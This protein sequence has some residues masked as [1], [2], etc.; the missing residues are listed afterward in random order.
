MKPIV[1]IVGRPSVGKTSIFNLLTKGTTAKKLLPTRDRQYADFVVDDREYACIDTGGLQFKK[2]DRFAE[3]ILD[4]INYAIQEATIIMLVIDG[5]VGLTYD[6][7]KIV[8]LIRK[9]D[10]NIML[11]VN[12]ADHMENLGILNKLG[13]SHVCYLNSLSRKDITNVKEE[14]AGITENIIGENAVVIE[15]DPNVIKLAIVGRPNVGKSTLVNRLLG[16]NRTIISEIPG[17]TLASV[18]IPYEHK[19]KKFNLIDTAGI[20][21][22]KKI[23]DLLEKKIISESLRAIDFAD[24]VVC[25]VDASEGIVDQD[26]KLISHIVKVGKPVII[27]V[28]KI[29]LLD[30]LEQKKLHDQLIF[31]LK[32]A[33]FLQIYQISALKGVK[34][35]GLMSLVHKTFNRTTQKISTSTLNNI[36]LEAMD[37]H[38]PP[39]INKRRA[40]LKYAH[41]GSL[42]PHIIIIHGTR[43][44]DLPKSYTRYLS[45]C[46]HKSLNLFGVQFK[47]VFKEK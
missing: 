26:F 43:T 29:D 1:T 35:S 37:A 11:V 28:N 32:H 3:L 13:L 31:S 45:N 39:L 15:D 19:G 6:D 22:K 14:I 17:T 7:E 30:K 36:L 5:R 24:V 33:K 16:N 41:I 38:Q 2:D 4:Q 8:S 12:F 23:N 47:L 34:I 27:A 42:N 44:K 10:K 25:M 20:R 21:K 46:F 9:S 40:K 18:E